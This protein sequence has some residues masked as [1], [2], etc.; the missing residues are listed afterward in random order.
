MCP[1]YWCLYV[2]D[3]VFA[4]AASAP[5]TLPVAV[6][7][8]AGFVVLVSPAW[9][10]HDQKLPEPGSFGS[11]FQTT[12]SWPAAWIALYS[13]GATTARKLPTRTTLA[14]GMCLIDDSSTLTG[15]WFCEVTAPC[16]R[17]RT[18]RAWSIPGTRMFCTYV[19]L[20]EIFAGR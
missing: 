15:K 9:R 3:T 19:Y 7:K 16:A 13:C 4:D 8:R 6:V 14:P 20:P 2:A 18:T 12:F 1:L 10:S 11:L 17:G 5:S